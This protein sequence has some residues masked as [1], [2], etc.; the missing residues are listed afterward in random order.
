MGFRGGQGVRLLDEHPGGPL[1]FARLPFREHAVTDPT[2]QPPATNR[3]RRWWLIGLAVVVIPILLFSI[4][5]GMAL[6]WSYSEGERAGIVQKF[7]KKGWVC[8]TWEGE[9]AMST[10]PG[11]APTIW[12]F[13]VRNETV[14]RS[15]SAGMGRRVVLQYAEH[16]GVPT[17]CF[18]ETPYYVDSVIVLEQ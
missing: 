5:V 10:V 7:S 1:S 6:D 11:V 3:R 17:T 2:P 13:T 9:L 15:I 8:K 14:A 12:P 16:R 18:G 4:Y